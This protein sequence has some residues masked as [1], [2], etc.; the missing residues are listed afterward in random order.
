MDISVDFGHIA[1]VG[2]QKKEIGGPIKN[3]QAPITPKH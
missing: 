3:V 2:A 1:G